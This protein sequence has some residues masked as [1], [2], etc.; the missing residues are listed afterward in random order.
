MN[1]P[2]HRLQADILIVGG[3]TAGCLAAIRAKELA[4]AARVL[5]MEKA[6]LERSGCLA[7]GVNALHG[8]LPPGAD[9]AR[10]L[11]WVREDNGGLVREDLVESLARRLP[12]LPPLLEE[13]GLPLPRTAEGG[14]VFRGPRSIVSHG[15][16]LK[17]I[18][19]RRV[20]QAGV[21]VLNRVAATDYLRAGDRVCGAVGIGRRDGA[22]YAVQAPAV[23]CATGGTAG[24]YPPPN[25]GPASRRTWYPPFNCGAGY[26]MGLRAGAELTSL[27]MRFVPL[28]V[29]DVQAPT[30]TVAQGVRAR[31]V[32]AQGQEYLREGGPVTTAG[33]L[34]RTLAERRAGRGPCYLD[35]GQPSPADLQRLAEAYLEMCP[36]A[37]LYLADRILPAAWG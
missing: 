34:E 4:P 37:V 18:L 21:E 31:Q 35:L 3:G 28:R 9:P 2:V 17:P 25:G 26:A 16:G 22:F 30:G 36:E 32:N 14:Y 19:A 24:L 7:A 15:G 33:R 23:I 11:A 1:P 8:Y 12:A 13:W 5:I 20:R 10:H 6:R 27:E 29:K